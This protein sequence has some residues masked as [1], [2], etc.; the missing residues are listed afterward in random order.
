[1]LQPGRLLGSHPTNPPLSNKCYT[2][3][4]VSF[5]TVSRRFR[6][7]GAEML[8]PGRLLGSH[9]T[10]TLLSKRSQARVMVL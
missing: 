4:L 9:P 5:C 3:E 1:M 7:Q 2:H 10:D 8:Q 6:S